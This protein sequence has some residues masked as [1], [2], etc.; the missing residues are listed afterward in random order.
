MTDSAPPVVDFAKKIAELSTE[1]AHARGE[2]EGLSEKEKRLTCLEDDIKTKR[3]AQWSGDIQGFFDELAKNSE[4]MDPTFV[5]TMKA[6]FVNPNPQFTKFH[7]FIAVAHS[8]H[9]NSVSALN[10]SLEENTGLKERLNLIEGNI[11]D[12][13][14][15]A[16]D[17]FNA[18]KKRFRP[19]DAL[20]AMG[21][22][23]LKPSK[24]NSETTSATAA[25][26]SEQLLDSIFSK[27]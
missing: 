17:G 16:S 24:G 26:A 4:S 22:E 18:Q 14:K 23:A 10:K 21:G 7:D 13:T 15:S 6:A 3:A 20:A 27:M 8:Q 25:T 12:A 5:D 2:I 1:L 19:E 11:N 9:K